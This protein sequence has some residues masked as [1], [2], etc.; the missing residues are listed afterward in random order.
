MA[1][2]TGIGLI[3]PHGDDANAV[4]DAVMRGVS[5]VQP[6]FPQLPRPAAAAVAPFDEAR[7]FTKLQL[8]G[9]DRVSQI[10]VGAATL[11]LADAGGADAEPERIGIYVGCG[12]G[13]AAA[14]EAAYTA[15][16]RSGR[17]PPLTIPAFM[18]NAPAAHI[19]MRHHVLGPVLTY[20]VACASSAVALAEA[21]RAV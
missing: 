19:A 16:P 17:V 12:M 15:A 7:W 20:S 13:G 3:A 4:F 8:P 5:A 1:V 11:A 9:V 10:A 14:L 21:A 18:P 6:V 2:V